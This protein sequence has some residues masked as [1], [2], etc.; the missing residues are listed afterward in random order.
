MDNKTQFNQRGQSLIELLVAMVIFALVGASIVMVVLDAYSSDRLGKEISEAYNFAQEGLEAVR[1]I[2]DRDFSLLVNGEHGLKNTLG[3]WE[4]NGTNNIKG[5]YKRVIKIES[6]Y[7]DAQGNISESGTIDSET[8]KV[9]SKVDWLF[10]PIRPQSIS[11][12]SYFTNWQTLS[13]VQTTQTDFKAGIKD[14]VKVIS[15]PEPPLDNGSVEL[16]LFTEGYLISQ[17][18]NT[19][20]AN[21]VYKTINWLASIPPGTSLKFQIRTASTKPGLG[22]AIFVG[23]DGTSLSYYTTSNTQIVTDPNTSGKRWFQW[24]AYF[25]SN[26]SSTPTLEEV[27]INYK[28]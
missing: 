22:T 17:A 4:F 8:K 23:P 14:N 13:W 5:K 19:G 21:P 9:T 18:L 15:A 10:S 6:V 27:V 3:Y 2:R 7:R 26:G 24:K 1:T 11:L 25:S 16:E 12:S 20:F 28:E